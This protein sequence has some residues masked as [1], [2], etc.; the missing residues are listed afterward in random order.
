M[1]ARSVE[2]TSRSGLSAGLPTVARYTC[3]RPSR[4]D[5]R[6]KRLPS[7]VNIAPPL[8]NAST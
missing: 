2:V 4:F 3:G 6:M 8:L 5:W 1:R 7:G